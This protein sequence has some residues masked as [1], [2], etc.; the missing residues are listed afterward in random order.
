VLSPPQRVEQGLRR[1]ARVS[2]I[3]PAGA[4][5]VRE[6][7]QL[8]RVRDARERGKELYNGRGPQQGR[9]ERRLLLA[10]KG[11]QFV[12]WIATALAALRVLVGTAC[13]GDVSADA[14]AVQG[15]RQDRERRQ[16]C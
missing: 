8:P 16:R 9:V 15:G 7:L 5:A 11:G 12:L 13:T 4:H 14:N 1:A 10:G 2:G 6:L 3:P